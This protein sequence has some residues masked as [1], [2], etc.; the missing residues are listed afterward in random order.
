MGNKVLVA[1][2]AG[3]LLVGA[4]F[5]TSMVSSPGV[6]AAEEETND[7]RSDAPILHDFGLLGEVLDDF[8]D[9]GTI[10]QDQADA[11]VEAV[12]DR[13]VELREERRSTL[14]KLGELLDDGV[15]TE[16][17]A[18]ELGEDNFLFSERFDEAWEDGELSADELGGLFH[19]FHRGAFRRGFRL[20]ALFDDGGIDQEEYDALPERN[21]L[22]QVDVTEYLEDG[23]ITRQ[24]L[25][26]IFSDLHEALHSDAA[27]TNS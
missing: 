23:L 9:D 25:R 16:E 6:A 5:V 1:F 2:V 13:A 22:K 26:E 19:P 11:I 3:G 8:V 4:G 18:S 15:I 24:E 21:P 10:S 7:D 27:N 17:E 20:G 14:E 12:E